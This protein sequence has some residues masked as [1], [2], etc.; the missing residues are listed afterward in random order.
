MNKWKYFADEEII[1]LQDSIV[2]MLDLARGYAGFPII[3]TSPFRTPEH[4]A[5]V[6]GVP[7][8]SHEKGIGVDI[9]KPIGEFEILKLIWALGLA[10]FQ[11]VLIYTKH[12]HADIDMEKPHPICVWMGESH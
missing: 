11:R 7:N 3:L 12:I 6:G 9:Q 10:G 2:E 8:S 4:N 1:G 5:E